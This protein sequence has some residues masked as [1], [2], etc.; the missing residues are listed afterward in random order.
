MK[1]IRVLVVEDQ[2]VVREGV[3]AILSFQPDIEVVGQ[4]EDGIWAVAL[5]KQT[6]P[7]VIL[8]DMVM[9]RQDGLASIRG[10]WC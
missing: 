6:Q 8:L 9:P 4:A 1:K 7:D 3:V 10:Y 5:A 2:T